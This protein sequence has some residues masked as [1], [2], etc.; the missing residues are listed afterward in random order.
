M[1]K[2]QYLH[3]GHNPNPLLPPMKY[4][5]MGYSH[6]V[7]R[8]DYDGRSCGLEV[9]QWQAHA[10]KWCRPNEYASGRDL[11]LV[12]YRWVALC[13]NPPFKEEVEEV[14]QIIQ[15]LRLSFAEDTPDT[16][17]LLTREE[18]DKIS[19]MFAENI[20]PRST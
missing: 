18:F 3:A 14:Q 2:S 16:P 9:Y 4:R 1:A 19:L 7:E 17:G 11:D 6:W 8:I 15:R 12:N 5:Q 13:P 20:V 10:G